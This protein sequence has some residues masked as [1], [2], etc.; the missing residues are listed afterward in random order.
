MSQPILFYLFL[1]QCA[2][3]FVSLNDVESELLYV[4][5][6]KLG[7]GNYIFQY[8]VIKISKKKGEFVFVIFVK[9]Y[10]WST[11]LAVF[12]FEFGTGSKWLT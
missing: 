11:P 4:G 6:S 5:R 12:T 7:H 1:I 3:I 8:T 9:V 2:F 10:T